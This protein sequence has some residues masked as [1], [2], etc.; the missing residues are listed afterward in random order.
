MR[1]CRPFSCG[2]AG[3]MKCG[4]D[5][6]LE[7]PHRQPRQSA[8]T[9]RAERRARCRSGSPSAGRARGTPARTPGE[10]LP[11]SAAPPAPR[12]GYRVTPSVSV[13]G[14]IRRPSRVRNQPLKSALHSSFGATAATNAAS[15][16]DRTPPPL[17]RRDQPGRLQDAR[18]SSR[19]PATSPR[20]PRRS[21]RARSLRGPKC[22]NR[23]R[24]PHDLRR[25][26]RR[27]SGADTAAARATAPRTSPQP[28]S[29]DA[30]ATHR[31]YPGSPRSAGRAPKRSTPL[32]RRPTAS[33]LR[34]SIRQVS[35][36]GIEGPPSDAV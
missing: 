20:A 31:T 4:V 29:R 21:N 14:S 3:R 27:R 23:R 26:R 1:S 30:H 24:R 34:C 22:G 19:P 5:A 35:K 8:G 25:Q 32:C 11:W 16:V 12:S 28:R 17:H 13:K 36:N 18:R 7:P 33:G 15:L 6:E 10:P 2:E 9:G